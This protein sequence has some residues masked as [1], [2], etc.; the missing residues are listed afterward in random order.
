M[1]GLKIAVLRFKDVGNEFLR[2]TVDQGKPAALNLHHDLVPFAET[3]MAP[4]QVDGVL[5]HFARY[6]AIFHLVGAV[7]TS[8]NRDTLSAANTMLPPSGARIVYKSLLR[9][10]ASGWRT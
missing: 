4:V 6:V 1:S 5:L 3:V 9:L 2:V 10:I 8:S 7:G